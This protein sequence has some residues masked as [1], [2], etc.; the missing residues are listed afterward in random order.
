MLDSVGGSKTLVVD[1]D[2][3]GPLNLIADLSKD[4]S[5]ESVQALFPPP[6]AAATMKPLSL[7]DVSCENVVFLC[8]PRVESMRLLA[9]QIHGLNRERQTKRCFLFFV[10][11]SSILAEQA[12]EDE[13][14]YGDLTIGHYGMDLIPFDNDLLSLEQEASFRDFFLD[15]DT[16]SL[17]AVANAIMKL[18]VLYG[19]IAQ[20]QGVGKGATLVKDILVRLQKESDFTELADSPVQ[21]ER[22]LL[23]DRTVDMV[24]PMA[25]QLTFAGLVD[26]VFRMHNGFVE[27][28]AE[29]VYT[30]NSDK[31][32]PLPGER[33]MHPL[34]GEDHVY[35]LIRD[36][37]FVNVKPQLNKVGKEIE[38]FYSRRSSYAEKSMREFLSF[39]K[40]LPVVQLQHRSLEVLLKITRTIDELLDD[41]DCR[42]RLAAEQELIGGDDPERALEYITETIDKQGPLLR[43]L[44]LLVIYSAT[45]GGLPQRTFDSIRN[46]L[47][48]S[49]GY[50][51][52]FSLNNLMRVGMLQIAPASLVSSPRS[53]F[54][55]AKK[56]LKLWNPAVNEADPD[57]IA[58]VYSGYAPLLVRLVEVASQWN[59][60]STE[61]LPM[62][63]PFFQVTQNA[64]QLARELL[65]DQDT[66]QPQQPKITLVFFIGGV[67]ATEVAALRF[68]AKRS[69]GQRRYLIATT[70]LITGDALLASL[71]DSLPV[72]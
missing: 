72:R 61:L 26:E 44:R 59:A 20:L 11:K 23:F 65:D 47:F 52:I 63:G 48:Q 41:D 50:E 70:K 62:F 43:V 36:V 25:T 64:H 38:E 68:L 71:I 3:L 27:L 8:R 40:Q 45:A 31:P 2:L 6:H 12:L 21:I 39:T 67:T 14:V 5:I 35:T 9:K 22:L 30:E 51:Y 17:F 16:T 15:G 29:L 54:R 57:D 34:N 13:G 33:I 46:E 10:P 55:R 69:G 37:N 56:P 18:Q 7:L 32:R 24:A 42:K 28:D 19:P 58:Y 4:T 49:Y 66:T 1:G 60:L 53:G